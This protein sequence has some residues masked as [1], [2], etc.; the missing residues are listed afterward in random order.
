V[1][2][3]GRR[4]EGGLTVAVRALAP[5]KLTL[6]L[7]VGAVRPDGLHELRAEMV[8]VDLADELWFDDGDGLAVEGGDPSL[9]TGPDNLVVRALHAVGRR[10][11]VRLV[12]RVPVGGGLGG[13]SSDAA[14]V[15]RWAGCDDPAVALSLGSDVPFCLVGGRAEVGGAGEVVTP[16]PFVAESF[17]L[18]VPP[19][20]VDTGAVYRAF[21]E[22]GPGPPG[23]NQLTRAAAAVAPE[24]AGWREALEEATGSEPILAG[25]GA[26]WFVEGRLEA[27][28]LAGVGEL[29][30][31]GATGRL[32]EVR[33]VP[34]GWAGAAGA[35]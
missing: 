32:F 14:A 3:A 6:A 26:T 16:L 31:G 19:F 21:D 1:G 5:A 15:L 22:L 34:A 8:A 10:A 11:A 7:E 12:K 13:G 18:L 17:V 30:R 20:A 29:R 25:S 4:R 28:G 35:G 2:P 9:D 23:A 24:L 33:T 27:F